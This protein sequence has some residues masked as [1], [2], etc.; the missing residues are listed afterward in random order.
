MVFYSFYIFHGWFCGHQTVKFPRSLDTIKKHVIASPPLSEFGQCVSAQCCYC[1]YNKKW[2]R[3]KLPNRLFFFPFRN[4]NI[5][6]RIER[7][8]TFSLFILA[9]TSAT[10]RGIGINNG[11]LRSRNTRENAASL[12]LVPAPFHS[13]IALVNL[14]FALV[15]SLQ[16]RKWIDKLKN[17][18]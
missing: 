15:G 6:N 16:T 14:R 1:W 4:T 10:I 9:G 8:W 13:S 18:L 7:K 11:Q 12:H 17:Y 2:T 3:R 5:Y